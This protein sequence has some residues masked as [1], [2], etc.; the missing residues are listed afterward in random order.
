M[1]FALLL[2]S[3]L[4]WCEFSIISYDQSALKDML[5]AP[6]PVEETTSNI[7]AQIHLTTMK[8]HYTTDF[9]T[10]LSDHLRSA[11]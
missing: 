3:E 1:N 8:S 6:Q 5:K 10:V 11:C 9:I 2:G 4:T 7:P